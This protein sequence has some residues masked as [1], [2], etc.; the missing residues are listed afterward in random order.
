MKSEI[1][2]LKARVDLAALVA[3]D[4]GPPKKQRRRWWWWHC[5]FHDD[6]NPSFGV[7]PDN[8]RYKC[9]GCGE[10][11]DHVDW[12][13]KYRNL[14]TREAIEELRRLAGLPERTTVSVLVREVP[15]PEVTT[16]SVIVKEVP[17]PE[18]TTT[19]VIVKDTPEPNSG[20]PCR[21]WQEAG[22]AFAMWAQEQLRTDAG[23]P[24][25]EYLRSGGL[26]DETIRHWGLGWNPHNLWRPAATWGLDGGKVFLPRGV[27]IPCQ[28]AGVLWYVKIRRFDAQGPMTRSGEKY[29]GPRGGRGALFGADQL[30]ANG[31]PLLLC[32]GERDFL[33]AWQELRDLVDVATLGGAGRR[34]LG[35][36]V[37]RLLPYKRILVVYDADAAGQKGA[38]SLKELSQRIV[39]VRVPHGKDLTDFHAAGGDLEAWLR[40]HLDRLGVPLV[41]IWEAEVEA[42][43]KEDPQTPDEY[44]SWCTRYA[45]LA[46]QLGW[47]CSDSPSWAAWLVKVEGD[48]SLGNLSRSP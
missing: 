38:A 44:L 37:L 40:Y 10:S 6:R 42:M 26:V 21:A 33:L 31:R 3:A 12:L 24:G 16:T 4:L 46:G 5:P 19:S 27:V 29:G 22:R 36:W 41:P 11:G 34:H 20:P 28:V 8:G 32:E 2:E 39:S 15:A 35:R 45:K 13:K 43:M 14:S 7:T 18:V 48:F 9:F 17:A 25:L 30:Q 23:G 1:G 47:P